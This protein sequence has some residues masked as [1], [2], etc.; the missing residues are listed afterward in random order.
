LKL[1]RLSIVA[2]CLGL[3]T[4]SAFAQNQGG[5]YGATRASSGRD[6]LTVEGWLSEGLTSGLPA[7]FS[8]FLVNSDLPGVQPSTVF[9]A[10]VNYARNRRTVQLFGS[11]ST[12]SEYG[13]SLKQF[14]GLSQSGEFGTRV[15]LPGGVRLTLSQMATYSP[16]Y[17]YELFPTAAPL[18]PGESV[19]VT[20]VYR[21]DS[22]LYS[23]SVAGT[24]GSPRA[25]EV[26]TM[27]DY[28]L[29]NFHQEAASILNLATYSVS[30][31]V[32]RALSRSA[33]VSAGYTYE[34]GDYTVAGS[35]SEHRIS[36]GASYSPPLSST[37]RVNLRVELSPS[38]VEGAASPIAGEGRRYFQGEADVDY[39][40]RRKWTTTLSYR[41]SVD[42][43]TGLSAPT[44]STGTRVEVTGIIAHRF[45][46]KA[47][48]GYATGSSLISSGFQN[49]GTASGQVRLRYAFSRSIAL[50]S[51]YVFASYDLGQQFGLGLGVPATYR[52]HEIRVGIAAFTPVFGR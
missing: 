36:I 6:Q 34:T 10:S 50:Y 17:L 39:P 30:T 43:V 28:G 18:P 27:F 16:P 45:D 24:F 31:K 2:I 52:L 22:A 19:P 25:T 49:F 20:P 26:T 40:F 21:T 11:A 1:F 5:L 7:E 15:R 41:R 47:M 32:S 9:S 35:T 12:Y 38:W 51:E 37:R 8:P 33:G 44:L 46:L 29:S 3:G 4:G 23:T 13:W 48:A 42:Y 14:S